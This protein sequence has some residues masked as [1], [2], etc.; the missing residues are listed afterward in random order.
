MGL[1]V[2]AAAA[3]AAAGAWYAT[4]RERAARGNRRGDPATFARRMLWAAL[5]PVTLARCDLRRFGEAT[6]G[7]PCCV[8]TSWAA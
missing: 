6:D 1:A 3:V 2:L 8:P 7:A 4:E 5:Q